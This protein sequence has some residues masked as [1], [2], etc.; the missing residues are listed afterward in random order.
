M[1]WIQ[2]YTARP[3]YAQGMMILAGLDWILRLS[4]RRSAQTVGPGLF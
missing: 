3:A 2:N 4:T 1:T